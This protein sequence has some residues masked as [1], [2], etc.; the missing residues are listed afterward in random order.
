LHVLCALQCSPCCL[1][2]CITHHPLTTLL[3]LLLLLLLLPLPLQVIWQLQRDQASKNAAHQVEMASTNQQLDHVNFTVHQT[4]RRMRL[5]RHKV[6]SMKSTFKRSRS[7][8]ACMDNN[9][10][11][12]VNVK[13][14]AHY[15]AMAANDVQHSAD[16]AAI[17]ALHLA[18]METQQLNSATLLQQRQVQHDD[19]IVRVITGSIFR[20]VRNTQQQEEQQVDAT[21][22]QLTRSIFRNVRNTQ[23]QEEQ[24]V[25]AAVRIITGSIFRNVVQ[26]VELQHAA[27]QR[28]QQQEQQH[29]QETAQLRDALERS[30]NECQGVKLLSSKA[31]YSVGFMS[32]VLLEQENDASAVQ[33]QLC[34]LQ[35]SHAVLQHDH[36]ALQGAYDEQ[37]QEVWDGEQ[38]LRK[39]REVIFGYANSVQL[40][41]RYSMQQQQPAAAQQGEQPAAEHEQGAQPAAAQE[42]VQQVYEVSQHGQTHVDGID[43]AKPA[44]TTPA[45]TVTSEHVPVQSCCC[46]CPCFAVCAVHKYVECCS[47]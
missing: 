23:Q 21:V 40:L 18:A 45:N 46:C 34:K 36:A 20:N 33:I 9:R 13:D 47:G 6:A 10:R 25:D 11:A 14:A 35:R 2:C 24:Q 42:Q 30:R 37:T 3:L 15:A 27:D 28:L 43:N 17:G 38:Q 12:A 29:L 41:V 16:I 19:D 5:A 4:N 22:S 31:G 7:V 8:M 26:Q 1:A 39:L 44:S 32:S